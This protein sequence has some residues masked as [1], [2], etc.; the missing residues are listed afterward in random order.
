MKEVKIG[1]Q[2]WMAE[3]LNVDKFR[4]GDPIKEAKTEEEW[5]RAA[6]NKQPAW[7]Y[8]ENDSVNGKIYGKLYNWFAVNDKRG[9]A[10]KGWRVASLEDWEQLNDL[11][12]GDNKAGQKIKSK[13]GWKENGNGTNSSGFSALPGGQRGDEG[14]FW[15]YNIGF[16]GNWWSST[17]YDNESA[18]YWYL[19]HVAANYD[20]TTDFG[21]SDIF[22]GNGHSIR[23]IRE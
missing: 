13:S 17:E 12:G 23:C 6:K 21:Y 5:L 20:I 2:I 1:K 11:L 15:S 8:F 10:P 3:N 9:L 19:D 22:K 4:N 14:D 7:C 18:Y 16:K